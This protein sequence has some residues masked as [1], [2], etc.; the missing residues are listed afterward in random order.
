M[1]DLRIWLPGQDGYHAAFR[2]LRIMSS[3]NADM[4]LEKLFILDFLLAYPTLLHKVYMPMELKRDF[5]ALDIQKPEEFFLKLPSSVS[6]FRDMELIQAEAVK[7]LVG[8]AIFDKNLYLK[9]IIS[10]DPEKMPKELAKKVLQRNAQEHA[11][12]HFLVSTYGGRPIKDLQDS[13]GLKRK[14]Y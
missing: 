10:L 9:K 4:E 11:L 12:I 5:R 8:K 1:N 13:T 3:N 7:S 6:L 14:I 2:M